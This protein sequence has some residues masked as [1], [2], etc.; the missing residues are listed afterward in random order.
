MPDKTQKQNGRLMTISERVTAVIYNAIDDINELLPEEN[1]ICKTENEMLIG[2]NGKLDSL[3]YLNFV[4]SLEN[5][6]KD[7]FNTSTILTDFDQSQPNP[8]NRVD[9]LKTYLINLTVDKAL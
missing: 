9:S 4:V 5:R 1:H 2:E 8:F 7:E 3:S 6:F